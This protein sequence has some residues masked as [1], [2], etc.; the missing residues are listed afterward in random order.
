MDNLDVRNQFLEKLNSSLV[1]PQSPEEVLDENPRVKYLYGFL[2]PSTSFDEDS[3]LEYEVADNSNLAENSLHQE[4]DEIEKEPLSLMHKPSSMGISFQLRG[5]VKTIKTQVIFARYF[6]FEEDKKKLWKRKIYSFEIDLPL[7]KKR[8]YLEENIYLHIIEIYDKKNDL[9][10]S[11]ITLV[12]DEKT[13]NLEYEEQTQHFLFQPKIILS[14]SE[15]S[16]CERP[17]NYKSG[18]FENNMYEFLYSSTRSL[19]FGHGVSTDWNSEKNKIWTNFIPAYELNPIDNK[20]SKYFSVLGI[21]S[22]NAQKISNYD[23]DSLN[24]VLNDFLEIY[25]KWVRNLSFKKDNDLSDEEKKF[26][27]FNIKKCNQVIKRIKSSIDFLKSDSDF[28]NA[29]QL[30]NQAIHEQNSWSKN[31]EYASFNWR[32]FQMAFILLVLESFI[33]NKR[34][35]K[36]IVDLLWFPTGGGKTE[37]YL[38]VISFLLFK[39][40]FKSKKEE[41]PGTQ[42]LIRYTLRLLTTQQFER[43]SAVVLAS[44]LIR[45][46]SN[47]CD[48]N[49]KVFSIGLWIGGDSSPNKREDAKKA[50]DKV[51]MQEKGDPRQLTK[52]PCCKFQLNWE[53]I[54]NQP[55][56]PRCENKGC[57]LNGILPVFTVDEDI[58]KERPSLVLGTSDKFIQIVRVPETNSLFNS[59]T[60]RRPELILQDELHLISGPLGSIAGLFEAAIDMICSKHFPI[61]IIGSTATIKNAENQVSAL[62]NRDLMQFPPPGIDFKDSCF[63]VEDDAQ[64]GRLYIGVSSIGRT[65]KTALSRVASSSFHHAQNIYKYIDPN[66]PQKKHAETFTTLVSYFNSLKELGGASVCYLDDVNE[67]LINIAKNLNED[68]YQIRELCEL[69]SRCSQQ[70]IQRYLENLQFSRDEDNA[71]DA[72]LSTNMISVGVDVSRLGLMIINGQTKSKS[73]YIQASSRVGRK[74]PGIVITIYNDSKV[75]DKSGFENFRDIHQNLYK[76]VEITSVTPFSPDCI[77]K[78]LPSVIVGGCRHLSPAALFSPDINLFR[79]TFDRVCELILERCKAIS[80][81]SSGYLDNLIKNIKSEWIAR[82]PQKYFPDKS[83]ASTL[84]I[85]AE[86]AVTLSEDDYG[87]QALTNV[88]NVE[89]V[90]LIETNPYFSER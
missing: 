62:F 50:L 68:R 63:A 39:S 71:I 53:I 31:S 87:F 15:N 51:E 27:E 19:C 56:N 80:P 73:E 75:R 69:T 23:S 6:S 77:K 4:S 74:Y 12:N 61:K 54:S 8:H 21:D 52:C 7:D 78:V 89:A 33:D 20:A 58:Y 35:S 79:D 49:S 37:A 18:S 14:S 38:C 65:G 86:K 44:E 26:A 64:P 72:C 34:E 42:I 1:G 47:L 24:K 67:F 3:S 81:E 13:T 85:E 43:A 83:K 57:K 66:S 10:L 40:S 30:A 17:L 82:K 2:N 25:I 45:K 36:S 60:G 41:D 11:T 16:F 22:L 90:S 32:P 5:I 29:F 55:I 46:K 84:L 59:Q 28:R 88:R 48:E 70:E 9:T 76:D